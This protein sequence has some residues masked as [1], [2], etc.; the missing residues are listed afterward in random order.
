MKQVKP[1]RRVLIGLSFALVLGA[2]LG[3]GAAYGGAAPAAAA[4]AQ[5]TTPTPAPAGPA[6]YV[7]PSVCETCHAEEHDVWSTSLH[8]Q[9]FSSPIFQEDWT[10]D[11]SEELVPAVPHHR[12]QP[13]RVAPTP[14][15]A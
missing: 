4:P 12:L 11:G 3:M 13:G 14:S 5:Q 9:A 8:S 2:S 6:T 7:G 10:K 15:K 1:G